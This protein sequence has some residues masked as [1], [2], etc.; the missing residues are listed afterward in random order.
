MCIEDY[1]LIGDTRTAGLV[2]NTGSIDWLCFPRFDSAACF[3][4]LLGEP[5][6]GR[7]L[8]QPAGGAVRSTRR[9]Y[10]QDTLV[11]ETEFTT[12]AGV[13][14]LID[15]MPP[16]EDIPNV[17]RLVEGV[18]G[19]VSMRME[20][21]IRF[22]YGWVVPWVRTV[23]GL[24]RDTCAIIVGDCP[25]ASFSSTAVSAS[26]SR[27]VRAKTRSVIASQVVGRPVVSIVS[28][29]L[30]SSCAPVSGTAATLV[31]TSSKPNVST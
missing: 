3:A 7:W 26:V 1:A 27:A 11:L 20:L 31:A 23:D 17:V 12:D 13:V 4:S 10:R 28:P 24:M 8:I 19:E 6:Q 18:E 21:V 29:L 14:R 22:D 16:G 9:R 25:L 30:T 2:S 5:E 15:C